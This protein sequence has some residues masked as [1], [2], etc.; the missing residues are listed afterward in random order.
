M[1]G[2]YYEEDGKEV[3]KAFYDKKELMKEFRKPQYYGHTYIAATNL[4]F[5]FT[6]TYLGE[7][8]WNKFKLIMRGSD[9]ICAK[10]KT[11]TNRYKKHSSATFIDTL[12]YA[13]FGVAAMG[14]I[15]GIPKLPHPKALGKIPKNEEER[16]ELEIYN[17]RDCY[18]TYKFMEFLQDGFNLLGG[19]TQLTAASTAMDIFRRKYLRK[20]LVKEDYVLGRDK[21]NSIHEF[22]FESYYGG[23]TEV[24]KRGL[25]DKPMRCYDINSLYPSCMLEEYPLP[26]TAV[27][28]D[29]DPSKELILSYEGVSEV[30]VFA[31]NLEYP[32]LPLKT[33][34]KL[35]FPNG[36]FRGVYTHI[37]LRKA[38]ELGYKLIKIHRTLYYKRTFFPFRNFVKDLY[39]KRLEYKKK[40]SPM[41]LV[42]K[43][44]MNSLYG[45]FGQRRMTDVQ[46][47]DYL[48][49][50]EEETK[51]TS[52]VGAATRDGRFFIKNTP[53]SC[54][55]PFV[56]PIF[57][58][59]T[60]AK[61]RLKLYDY[62]V[63]CKAVYCDTDSVTTEN[64]LPESDKLGAMKLEYD[65][66][67]AIF[68]KPKMYMLETTN[69]EIVKLKGVHNIT[70]EQFMKILEGEKVSYEKFTKLRE[71]IRRDLV[72]NSI[73]RVEKLLSLEDNKRLWEEEFDPTQSQESVAHEWY[74]EQ[75]DV[76]V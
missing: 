22:I 47:I 25:I 59:Y 43:L 52:L 16:I 15:L 32:L 8:D 4:A 38:L 55:K 1:G 42:T 64:Y 51:K 66:K 31:P 73:Q 26:E 61:A 24:F 71:G 67:R 40:G 19:K 29:Q 36:L 60:T 74:L 45:K 50:S 49:L 54:Y 76:Q 30:T 6:V 34:T 75:E 65:I 56:I 57:A 62:I 39:A 17:K 70:N 72:V 33:P 13:G 23:R 11:P 14:K 41:E 12:N 48:N 44:L 58:S 2:I 9:M 18:I 7:S 53:K 69:K 35:L 63:K 5:D 46:V 21:E 3:Y 37:E 68:V 20:S 10:R 28:N 27:Y